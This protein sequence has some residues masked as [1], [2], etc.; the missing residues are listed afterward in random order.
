MRLY[1]A[2]EIAAELR[3]VGFGVR[4]VRSFGELRLARAIGRGMDEQ[5][6]RRRMAAQPTDAEWRDGAAF[7]IVNDGEESQLYE[8]VDEL[9]ERLVPQ[10]PAAGEAGDQVGGSGPEGPATPV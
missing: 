2:P 10:P 3:R 7:V 5:D 9:W 6:V 8:T 4:V 1:R